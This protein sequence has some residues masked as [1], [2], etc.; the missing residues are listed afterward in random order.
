MVMNKKTKG[1]VVVD[2]GDRT[3]GLDENYIST[4]SANNPGPITRSIFIIR[5][6]GDEDLFQNDGVLRYGQKIF[7]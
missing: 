5:K 1:Y 2:I 7:L 3:K 6:T 4:T